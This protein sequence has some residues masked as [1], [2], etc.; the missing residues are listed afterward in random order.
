MRVGTEH[1]LL[2]LLVYP[3]LASAVGTD[4]PHARAALERM[5][6]DALAAIGL[7]SPPDAPPLPAGDPR[8]IPARPKLGALIRSHMRLTPAA[9]AVLRESSKCMRRGVSHPGPKH[10]LAGL[11]ELQRPDPAAE[12]LAA[13]GIEPATIRGR[14]ADV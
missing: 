2:A 7:E 9:T 10:V 3:S 1:V 13:L 8:T 6:G 12:L 11:L 14:L 5:D 4:A